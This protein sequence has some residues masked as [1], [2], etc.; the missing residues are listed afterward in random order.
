VTATPSPA[1]VQGAITFTAVVT[2]NGT[3]PTGTVNFLANGTIALGTGT[4]DASGKA[5][6]TYS[7]LGAGTYQITAVY[8]GDTND[9]GSTS[10]AIT[11]V[12]GLLATT[13]D[14][15]TASTTGAN[16]QTILVSTVQNSGSAGPAPTGTVTF[17]SGT[18]VIGT[19][20]LN[21]DGVATLTPNLGAGNYTIIASYPG[22]SLHSPSQSS[23]IS[24]TTVG[25]AYTL[26]VTPAT[27]SVA[28]S[29]NVT[30]TVTLT[31]V[32]GFADNIGL[33]C[34]SLPAGVNCHFSNIS[35]ALAANGTSTAQLVIDTNNP[36]GGGASAMNKQPGR[37]N[38]EMA[39][40]FL[41]FSIFMGWILWRFRKR[42]AGILSTVLILVL[43]GAAML[44][45]GCIGY[46]Q[47]SAAPGTYTI[48][49]VGVGAN[50]NVTEYQNVALTI[51]K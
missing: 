32:S 27:V 38:V 1:T 22:D 51:T 3:T 50:S 34:G 42:H 43:S 21:A 39:G 30:V 9:A 16:S 12:V 36:L 29:Q 2:G 41:P 40:L 17:L 19:A 11:E 37:R 46:T 33:G 26:T 10:A 14:L 20:P 35:L 4:L 44:A 6:V 13:T 49:V 8:N 5:S 25:S 23:P 18:N 47:S 45:T 7:T 31:S 48:Q 24:I 15:S 28:T